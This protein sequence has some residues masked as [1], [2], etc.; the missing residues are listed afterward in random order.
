[1]DTLLN[2]GESLKSIAKKK[3]LKITQWSKISGVKISTLNKILYGDT[4]N[5]NVETLDALLS[6][7]NLSL[8]DIDPQ[9][10]SEKYSVQK[11]SELVQKYTALSPRDQSIIQATLD[12][13][14]ATQEENLPSQTRELPLYLIP[15]SA[16]FGSPLDDYESLEYLPV[17]VDIIPSGTNFLIRVSGDSMTPTCENGDL[18]FIQKTNTL[19]HKD[20]GV[21][22]IN[23]EGYIKEFDKINNQFI[24]HNPHYSPISI[25]PYDHIVVVGKVLDYYTPS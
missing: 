11:N 10:T 24:S 14:L 23:G 12:K 1:M 15:A 4:K 25:N 17:P 9:Y 18:A 7:V 19:S 6:S 16:G 20:I 5:P 3:H 8:K 2:I 22:T 21:V 13:M